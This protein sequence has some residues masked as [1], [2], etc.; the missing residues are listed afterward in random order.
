[1]KLKTVILEHKNDLRY[2]LSKLI[3][4]LVKDPRCSFSIEEI[5]LL[6]KKSKQGDGVFPVLYVK[7]TTNNRP[8][9]LGQFLYFTA[10]SL[11]GFHDTWIEGYLTA[12]L[13]ELYK[14][15]EYF[16]IKLDVFPKNMIDSGYTYFFLRVNDALENG[17]LKKNAPFY[18]KLQEYN[19]KYV[20]IEGSTIV[21]PD[22]DLMLIIEK[23][24]KEE[25]PKNV[26][27]IF[28]GTGALTKVALMNQIEKALCIDKDIR[29]ARINLSKFLNR[30]QFIE[31]DLLSYVPPQNRSYDLIISDIFIDFSLTFSKRMMKYYSN[32]T[33]RMIMTVSFTEDKLWQE[34]VATELKK[35]FRWVELIDTKRL[36]IADCR[37]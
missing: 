28:C 5:K 16:E 12:I 9:L 7:V 26:M 2:T 3:K 25:R 20:L 10:S 31:K 24:C 29:Y 4:S 11:Y 6:T 1:M 17:L 19:I 36:V 23:L 15:K 32:I 13:Q 34:L 27:D 18:R 37:N 21:G 33:N 30:V 8:L 14:V 35:H 22:L